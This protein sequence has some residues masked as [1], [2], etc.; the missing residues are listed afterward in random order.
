MTSAE[1]LAEIVDALES[2]GLRCLVM[3][4]HAV[5]YYGFE[6]TTIDFDLHLGADGWDDLPSRLTQLSLT[7]GVELTE[8]NTWRPGAFRRFLIGRLPD[9]REE[10]LEFWRFNHLLAPFPELYS[11]R[12]TGEYGGR[13]LSFLSL[14]DLIRSKETDREVDWQDI[15]RLE[16]FLDAR[17]FAAAMSDAANRTNALSSVRSRRGF[18]RLLAEGWIRDAPLAASAIAAVSS[19]IP[20]AYLRPFV[21]DAGAPPQEFRLE[22]LVEQKLRTVAGGSLAHISVVE[23][24]RLQ[25]KRLR[26]AADAADKQAIRAA[27]N[28]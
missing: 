28:S 2:V 10:W 3:G 9:G 18:E 22:P 1:R 4:G 11:R 6:R 12:E 15:E 21:A 19:P 16:E 13:K 8:G 23:I 25:Y 27:Q 7:A 24:V 17:L 14:P 26:K 5:R 20:W